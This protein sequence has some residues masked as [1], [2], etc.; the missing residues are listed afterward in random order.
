MSDA[1][2]LRLVDW[3]LMERLRAQRAAT[4]DTETLA[5]AL[6]AETYFNTDVANVD[7]A[8]W[9]RVNY[10]ISG[11]WALRYDA[12]AEAK[13]FATWLADQT[14]EVTN[15]ALMACAFASGPRELDLP[16]YLLLA[17]FSP[18]FRAVAV[19]LPGAQSSAGFP[20]DGPAEL[21][22]AIAC[23]L[24]PD[25]PSNI[26]HDPAAVRRI[27]AGLAPLTPEDGGRG[28]MGILYDFIEDNYSMGVELVDAV[29]GCLDVLHWT[30]GEAA[31][32][33]YGVLVTNG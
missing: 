24:A 14:E 21:P 17:W 28:D 10:A 22:A 5:R 11:P 25:E 3:P 26:L 19:G 29:D 6:A 18:A 1:V 4:G 9:S 30:Y 16:D 27:N 8:G 7:R 12:N 20:Y 23:A 13:T 32:R 33:G 2:L 31:E 15:D